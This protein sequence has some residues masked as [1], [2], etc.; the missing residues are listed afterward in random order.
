MSL[1][2]RLVLVT[3]TTSLPITR[4]EA[5]LHLKIEEAQT[6]EDALIDGL[7]KTA[8]AR[9]EE[10]TQ[11]LPLKKTFD[12]YPDVDPVGAVTLPRAPLVSVSS[13]KGYTDTDLTDSGGSAMSTS[14]YYVDTASE[15]GRVIP[16]GGATWPTAT[17]VL[18]RYV[19]RF[20]AGH[21]SQTTSVPDYIKTKLKQMVAR[22][23]EF[24]GDQSQAEIDALMHEV[25]H[26]DFGLP[27]WG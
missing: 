23:Y 27:E 16:L 18:N 3:D 12:F 4:Q 17:R 20:E 26:D 11:R 22:A 10:W 13:V 1:E 6:V 14:D 8:S 9:Y 21:T 7:I 19:I 24:R 5:K 2:G 25:V 15:P